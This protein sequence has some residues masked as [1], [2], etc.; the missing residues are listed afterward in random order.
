MSKDTLHECIRLMI[1][2]RMRE[3]DMSDGSKVPWGSPEHVAELRSRIF[4]LSRWRDRQRKGSEARA[5]YSRIVGRL[6]AE[7]RSALQH[8]ERL[9]DE[10]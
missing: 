4:D 1:E 8:A 7:L 5:N 10:Q 6:K 9:T 3:A 2:A